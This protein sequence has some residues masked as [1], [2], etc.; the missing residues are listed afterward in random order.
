[1]SCLLIDCRSGAVNTARLSR[2]R[3]ADDILD[4]NSSYHDNSIDDGDD[5]VDDVIDVSSPPPKPP[6]D[7]T[8]IP[9]GLRSHSVFVLHWSCFHQSLILLEVC[10]VSCLHQA[11]QATRIEPQLGRNLTLLPTHLHTKST[12]AR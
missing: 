5:N 11:F 2:A 9:A 1:V 6:L 4:D 7:C 8:R 3:S 12:I 10:H